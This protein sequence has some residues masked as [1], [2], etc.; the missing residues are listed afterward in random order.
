MELI[1]R[2][3]EIK[4]T[5]TNAVQYEFTSVSPQTNILAFC[6]LKISASSYPSN[7]T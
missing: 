1:I 3:Y 4:F 2:L 6:R 7:F 5:A